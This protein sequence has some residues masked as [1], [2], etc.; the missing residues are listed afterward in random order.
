MYSTISCWSNG[1][2]QIS[3]LLCLAGEDICT[4]YLPL[5]GHYTRTPESNQ[6]KYLIR[7]KW[8]CEEQL[9]VWPDHPAVYNHHLT[10]LIQSH[11]LTNLWMNPS[12]RCYIVKCTALWKLALKLKLTCRWKA[13]VIWTWHNDSA[14]IHHK[15]VNIDPGEVHLGPLP[16]RILL[17]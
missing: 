6:H 4:V 1:R 9:P 2:R 17:I 5:R 16:G 15:A 7:V 12:V 14:H 8:G 11:I 3:K 13:S 10:K